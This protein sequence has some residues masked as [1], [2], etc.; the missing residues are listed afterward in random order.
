MHDSPSTQELLSAVKGFIDTLAGENLSGHARFNARVAANVLATVLR[1]IDQ[2]PTADQAEAVRLAAL[3][4]RTP[5]DDDLETLNS[6][7][8]TLIQSGKI[9]E[10]TPNLLAHLKA[11]AI[12]QLS[13][14]QPRYSGLATAKD[15]GT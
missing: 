8:C 3:L 6:E 10:T 13:I 11:T 1:E 9:D 5:N 7:L 15:N 2:R 4:D 12:D 14:D